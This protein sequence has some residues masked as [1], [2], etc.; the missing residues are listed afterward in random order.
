MFLFMEIQEF[1]KF[2]INNFLKIKETHLMC[3][4][5]EMFVEVLEIF[6]RK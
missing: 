1:A 3:S 6:L 4:D 5:I 2:A